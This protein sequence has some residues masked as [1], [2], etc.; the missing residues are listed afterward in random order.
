MRRLKVGGKKLGL[1]LERIAPSNNHNQ[2]LAEVGE[3]LELLRRELH[4]S[5]AMGKRSKAKKIRRLINQ[6]LEVELYLRH[7]WCGGC[8]N[9]L[10]RCICKVG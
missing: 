6:E 1:D 8:H 9:V 2:R 5:E 7:S 4:I 3:N 10:H